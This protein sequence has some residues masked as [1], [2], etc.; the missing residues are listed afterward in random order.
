[1]NTTKILVVHPTAGIQALLTRLLSSFG[2]SVAAVR[3][4][5]EAIDQLALGEA[6]VVLLDLDLPGMSGL[7][8]LRALLP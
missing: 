6:P 3:T 5:E 1:M 8:T 4:G 2:Y 7:E